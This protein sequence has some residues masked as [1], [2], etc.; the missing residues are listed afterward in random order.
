MKSPVSWNDEYANFL[1]QF[2]LF[3]GSAATILAICD[4]AVSRVGS[5]SISESPPRRPRTRFA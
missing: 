2:W 1:S 5:L 3:L 4:F